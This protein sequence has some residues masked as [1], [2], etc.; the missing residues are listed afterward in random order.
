MWLAILGIV[1]IAVEGAKATAAESM[2]LDC[3]GDWLR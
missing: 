2:G 3:Q 1:A